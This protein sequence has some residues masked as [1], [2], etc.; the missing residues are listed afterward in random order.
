[1]ASIAPRQ[2]GSFHPTSV[3]SEES[4]DEAEGNPVGLFR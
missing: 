4:F 2:A 3:L 1:M